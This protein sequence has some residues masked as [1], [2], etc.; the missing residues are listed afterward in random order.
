[1]AAPVGASSNPSRALASLLSR[2]I[3]SD[4]SVRP[5]RPLPPDPPL[6]AATSG[7]RRW[8]RTPSSSSLSA[9]SGLT[10]ILDSPATVFQPPGADHRSG[11]GERRSHR[12]SGQSQRGD[13]GLRLHPFGGGAGGGP[14]PPLQLRRYHNPLHMFAESFIE[15]TRAAASAASIGTNAE[16][17]FSTVSGGGPSVAMAE[18]ENSSSLAGQLNLEGGGAG[19][20]RVRKYHL[21]PVPFTQGV[22]ISIDRLQLLALLDQV[23]SPTEQ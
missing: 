17:T 16:L 4:S 3:S 6:S 11:G 20:P 13:L 10:V 23:R 5:G 14:R 15:R 12:E 8:S 9:D 18:I 19:G 7:S 1:M 2:Q 22:K 21:L